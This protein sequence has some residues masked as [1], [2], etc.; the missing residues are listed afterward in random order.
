MPARTYKKI[1]NIKK[2]DNLPNLFLC[3][4]ENGSHCRSFVTAGGA[5]SQRL[6]VPTLKLRLMEQLNRIEIRGNVGA[7]RLQ[8]VGN[9][10]VAKIS[11]ATNYVYKG[12]DGEPVIE[13]T[14][15]YISAWEGK[16]MPDLTTIHKGDKIS[17][18][19][20]LRSQRYTAADGTER[21]A[22]DVLASKVA[23]IE[24]D[25]FLQYEF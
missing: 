17:V 5:D 19:G 7:V 15:H 8:V 16:N 11:V 6:S 2:H 1:R 10:R 24:T 14:W 12:R 13:T 25:D 18:T 21:T 3:S 20:R 4:I 22:Y 23:L 9:S